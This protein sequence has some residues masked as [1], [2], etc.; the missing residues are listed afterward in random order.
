[1]RLNASSGSPSL[2]D[3][4][5]NSE[6]CATSAPAVTERWNESRTNAFRLVASFFCFML[7]KYYNLTYIIISLVFLSPF[8]GYVSSALL[9][10]YLHHKLGQRVIAIICGSCHT[11]AYIIIALHPPYIVLV[12]AFILAGFGN[13]VADAAWNA[14]VGNL[15]NSSELLG[16]L[17]AFYGVGGVAS[18]LIVT[19][20][21]TKANLEWYAFYYIM[22][23]LASTETIA[24]ASAFRS[25]SGA[26]YRRIYKTNE[27]EK[28][29]SLTEA[30]FRMPFAQ[31]ALGGW[32]VVFMLRVRH[33][34]PFASG[35]SAVSFWLGITVGRAV[36]GFATPRIGVKLATA[37]YIGAAGSL[38][39]IFWLVPQ[40]YI[41]AVAVSFQGFF[42]GP[43][44]PNAILV[45]GK[46]LPRQH[47]VVVIGF[48]AAFGGCGAA[49]LPFLTGI[50]AEAQGPKVLQP[51][52]LALLAIT[53]GI[54]F[55]F[56]S[57]SKMK[58]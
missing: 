39:L 15:Y 53:L 29:V 7:E 44:F 3:E 8:L 27:L 5:G 54:W 46:L 42:M 24:L 34:E 18:P 31:V 51:I 22:I 1:M 13:G 25:S 28:E 10:N 4:N 52:V 6:P 48:A 58:E 47:H 33:G 50:L 40:F 35:M 16:F 41:S 45:A 11:A 23:G 21:I 43:L 12:L 19:A 57:T 20:L 49:V 32:I 38:E 9:N 36:L 37:L 55:C 56:P 17:H 30:L 14:W 2:L 26:E